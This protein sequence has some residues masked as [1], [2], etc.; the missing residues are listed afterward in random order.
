MP[1]RE[2][3]RRNWIAALRSGAVAYLTSSLLLSVGLV[4]VFG[5]RGASALAAAVAVACLLAAPLGSGLVV[6]GVAGGTPERSGLIWSMMGAVATVLAASFVF[7]WL[8]LASAYHVPMGSSSLGGILG[9]CWAPRD[10][11][12]GAM[13]AGALAVGIWL[14]LEPRI[15]M[16]RWVN[17]MVVVAGAISAYCWESVEGAIA[18]TVVGTGIDGSVMVGA[19]IAWQFAV[20]TGLCWT[21][22]VVLFSSGVGNSPFQAR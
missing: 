16:R 9:A 21:L 20:A 22:V 7:T 6:Y 1:S 18:R 13:I 5:T 10:L 3:P 12:T 8:W 11:G 14:A 4:I 17:I 15:Q 19:A 2:P